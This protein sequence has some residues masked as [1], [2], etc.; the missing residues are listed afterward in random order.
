MNQYRIKINGK[1]VKEF[2]DTD[3]T[4]NFRGEWSN[5]S[6]QSCSNFVLGTKQ[7]AKIIEGNINLRSHLELI[8]GIL[9][10]GY[11]EINKFEVIKC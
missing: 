5:H 8:A 2:I 4:Q 3:M 1:Y 11:F 6:K 10:D 7:T 9:K